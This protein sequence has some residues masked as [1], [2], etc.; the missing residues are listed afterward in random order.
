M[1]IA[2]ELAQY[3]HY[4]RYEKVKLYKGSPPAM[5]LDSYIVHEVA[6]NHSLW[7]CYTCLSDQLP[8]I[9]MYVSMYMYVFLYVVCMYMYIK[10]LRYLDWFP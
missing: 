5:W 9:C 10:T 2:I 8:Y 6:H 7:V 1:L 3:N 4:N